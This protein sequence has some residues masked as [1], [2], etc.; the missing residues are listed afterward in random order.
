ME[1]LD[2]LTRCMESHGVVKLY[3]KRL[4]VNDNPKH[5]IYLAGGWKNINFIPNKGYIAEEVKSKSKKLDHG[6]VVNVKY[7]LKAKVSFNWITATGSIEPVPKTQMILY[8]QYPE[9]RLSG[10]IEG[11][12]N[13]PSECMNSKEIGRLLFLGITE[14]GDVI[15][16]ATSSKNPMSNELD[17]L[18]LEKQGVFLIIPPKSKKA[19]LVFLEKSMLE[20]LLEIHNKGWIESKRLSRGGIQL[21]CKA[22]NCGG[23]TLEAELGIN[24]NGSPE[25]D[26]LGWEVKS[27][28]VSNFKNIDTGILTLFTPE[29][30]GGDYKNKGIDFFVKHYGYEDKKGRSNRINFG[31]IHKYGIKQKSTTLTLNLKG[32]NEA[33]KTFDPSGGIVLMSKTQEI[34]AMWDFASLLNHWN[35][36][37]SHAVYVP[38]LKAVTPVLMYKYGSLVKVCQKTDFG[39]FLTALSKGSV[40]YDPGIKIELMEETGKRCV[41][42]RSQFRIK[43]KDLYLLYTNSNIID[44]KSFRK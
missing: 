31:G 25:P 20:K 32:F 21:P 11:C 30:T 7:I 22:S 39:L 3:V 44:L 42:K 1:S 41:K 33:N 38:L 35:H 15:G 26:Y 23:Y 18:M 9:V 19:D 2:A 12:N 34:A 8:P 29:P 43:S 17:T 16:F 37:H 14:T 5:G 13:G 27:Y 40:Y 36:K 4:S 10:F 28:H 24:P 6:L